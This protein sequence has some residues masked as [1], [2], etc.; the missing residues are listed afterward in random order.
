MRIVR[1]LKSRPDLYGVPPRGDLIET[2]RQYIDEHYLE[3]LSLE[4][5]AAAVHAN[6][7]YLSDL[8]SKRMGMTLTDY[9]NKLRLDHAKQLLLSRQEGSS[10]NDIAL[11]SGFESNSQ[12]SKIFKRATGLSPQEYRK[13]K[14][15][16]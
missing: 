5:V 15:N 1:R 14:K 7:N 16:G 4:G 9:R 10:I 2:A 3:S 11:D 6:K 8:F 12:F 13:N